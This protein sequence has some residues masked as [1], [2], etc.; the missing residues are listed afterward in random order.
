MS[1]STDH[2]GPEPHEETSPKNQKNGF[3]SRNY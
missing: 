2:Y 3:W 1:I